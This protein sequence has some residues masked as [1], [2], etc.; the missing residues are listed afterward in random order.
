MPRIT[1]RGVVFEH[2][3]HGPFPNPFDLDLE[4]GWTGVVGPNGAGKTT[5]LRLITAE[6]MPVR[7]SI[8]VDAPTRV[9]AQTVEWTPTLAAELERFA[10]D[11]SALAGRLRSRSRAGTRYRPANASVGSSAPRWPTSHPCCCA[12]SP[13]II[14]TPTAARCCSTRCASFLGSG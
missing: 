12:T 14:S 8:R 2:G 5:L 10:H 4:P 7:G 9:L 13:A 3:A 6:L 1:M 11:W